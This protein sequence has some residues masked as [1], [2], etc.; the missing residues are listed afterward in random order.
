MEHLFAPNIHSD[1]KVGVIRLVWMH[2]YSR[3]KVCDEEF[4]FI[5]WI[6]THF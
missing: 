1:K 3:T 5:L 6:V 4:V 2:V